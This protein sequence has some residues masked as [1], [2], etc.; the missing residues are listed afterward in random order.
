MRAATGYTIIFGVFILFIFALFQTNSEWK[1]AESLPTLLDKKIP[2]EKISLKQTSFITDYQGNIISEMH[3]NENRKVLASNAIPQIVKDIF[4]TVEDQHFYDHIGFDITGIGR[5]ALINLQSDS[6]EQG[7]S[8]LTQQLARNLF[9]TNEKTYNRKLSELMYSYQLERKLS[10]DEILALYINTVYF[11]NGAYGI[12]TASQTYFNQS[13]KEATLGE[14]AFLCAIPNNPSVYNP[15]TNY[16]NTK[17]RQ[18]RILKN[19]L[20]VKKITTDEY[21]TAMNEQITLNMSQ[22]LDMYPDYTTYILEELTDII[23][24]S[25]GYSEQIANTTTLEDRKKIQNELDKKVK[26]VLQSGIMIETALHPTIQETASNALYNH[27]PYSDVQG[28]VVVIDHTSNQLVAIIGGKDYEKYSFHRGFQA[29]RQPGSAIKPLLVYGPYFDHTGT[30]VYEQINANNYCKNGYCPKNYG[31]GQYGNVSLQTALTY[32]Y[33]TPAIRLMEKMGIGT[34]FSYLEKF[35]FDKVVESDKSLPAAIG[36]FAYGMSPLEL[37]NAY[38]TFSNQGEFIRARGII[39]VADLQG[40]TLYEWE[41]KSTLV[42][43]EST[44][45]TMRSLLSSVVKNG[46]GKDAYFPTDYIGGKTGTT[47]QVK[48]L[49]FIGMT[50]TYT[51]GVWVGNDES[52]S[53]RTVEKRRPQIQIWK[54]IMK[55]SQ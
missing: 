34:A 53:V 4:I 48:D 23:G 19:M 8:T 32:S 37:T 31:G 44:N 35:E 42:W 18:E 27:L 3:H 52:K 15:V 25:E 6:I 2:L 9:L 38:T 45:N 33:N 55:A 51:A 11:Q 22:K 43:S 50:E 40:N 16:E 1:K 13:I 7:G 17:K 39:R 49:W 12:E 29:Y 28:S 36:G 30:S 14:I 21:N 47:N 20:D 24:E 46:T 26:E 41:K 5:A 54:E 10:K